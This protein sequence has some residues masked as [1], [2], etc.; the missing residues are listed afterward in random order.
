MSTNFNKFEEVLKNKLGEI[1]TKNSYAGHFDT[2]MAQAVSI[3]DILGITEE[4][5]NKKYCPV[6]PA[7]SDVS[8]QD[9]KNDESTFYTIS[10]PQEEEQ[11]DGKGM[12]W[13]Q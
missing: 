2:A 12:S 11:L 4:A 10:N 6:P 9:I 13:H 5:Y 8:G 7:V 3:W 1:E